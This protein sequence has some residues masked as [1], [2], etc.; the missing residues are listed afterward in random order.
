MHPPLGGSEHT[1]LLTKYKQKNSEQEN[2]HS[3]VVIRID[4]FP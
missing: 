3:F 1:D 2:L 4:L